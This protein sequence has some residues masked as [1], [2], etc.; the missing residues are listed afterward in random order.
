[1]LKFIVGK[2]LHWIY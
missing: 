1:M 2:L